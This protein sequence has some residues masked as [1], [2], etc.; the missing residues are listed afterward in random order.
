M[1][2]PVALMPSLR[3]TRLDK[4]FFGSQ[5]GCLSL[6]RQ[7]Y[8]SLET[9]RYGKIWEKEVWGELES[10]VFGEQHQVPEP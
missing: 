1:A 10:D 6:G 5:C 2:V 4:I 8:E 3:G 7:P 9:S